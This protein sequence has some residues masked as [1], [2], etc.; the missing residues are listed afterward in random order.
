M[1]RY[2]VGVRRSCNSRLTPTYGAGAEFLSGL[3]VLSCGVD[4]IHPQQSSIKDLFMKSAVPHSETYLFE[5]ALSSFISDASKA[6][7][8]IQK[9]KQNMECRRK[10]EQRLE[11]RRLQRDTREFEF[12]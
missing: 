3:T 4:R 5:N 2:P 6:R 9:L 11:E 8:K 10:L 12:E 1:T 7:R